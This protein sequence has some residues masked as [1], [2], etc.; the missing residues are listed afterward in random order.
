MMPSPSSEPRT[1]SA[2]RSGWGIRPATLPARSMTPAI[3]RRRAVGVAAV[4]RPPASRRV[5]VAEQDLAVALERVELA[6]SAK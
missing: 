1:A 3:A 6:S 5:D 2:A 4:V